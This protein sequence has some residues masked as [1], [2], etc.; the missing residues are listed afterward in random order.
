MKTIPFEVTP[1]LDL[2]D[3]VTGYNFDRFSVWNSRLSRF[4]ESQILFASFSGSG[5]KIDRSDKRSA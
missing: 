3:E 2:P 5:L 1:A 4:T